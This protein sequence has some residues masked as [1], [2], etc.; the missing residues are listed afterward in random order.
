M[1]LAPQVEGLALANP[2]H[3]FLKANFD[4]AKKL[5]S[6]HQ[7]ECLPTFLVSVG[8][9]ILL[10]HWCVVYKQLFKHNKLVERL[11]GTDIGAL[12]AAVKAHG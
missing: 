12:Q 2:Q 6:H 4:K 1:R 3:T 5:A 11:E 9:K 8:V 10:A 7:I